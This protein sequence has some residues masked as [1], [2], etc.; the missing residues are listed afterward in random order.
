MEKQR[1]NITL[2]ISET[3]YRRAREWA[4]AHDISLSLL[5][6]A[7]LSTVDINKTALQ[8]IGYKGTMAELTRR[9]DH[10]K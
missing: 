3:A 4:G 6:N 10:G 8:C 5:V 7:F 9:L 1:R 2:S